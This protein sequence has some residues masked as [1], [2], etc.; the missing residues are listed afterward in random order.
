MHIGSDLSLLPGA[1][2]LT[3]EQTA[4]WELLKKDHPVVKHYVTNRMLIEKENTDSKTWSLEEFKTAIETNR[5]LV[6]LEKL[7]KE[8]KDPAR[9]AI[10]KGQIEYL[11]KEAK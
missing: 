11:K 1:N 10:V 8:E 9:L 5:D 4:A 3:K 2:T 7:V 6:A